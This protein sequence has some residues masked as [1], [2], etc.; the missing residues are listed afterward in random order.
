MADQGAAM[1]VSPR[2]EDPSNDTKPQGIQ[3]QAATKRPRAEDD[4]T[5]AADAQPAPLS[6]SPDT[7]RTKTD[8]TT[9]T[10]E[11][12]DASEATMNI[13]TPEVTESKDESPQVTAAANDEA[14]GE[15]QNRQRAN[16]WLTSPAV[17]RRRAT[18]TTKESNN[19]ESNDGVT[20]HA[21]STPLEVPYRSR[22]GGERWIGKYKYTLLRTLV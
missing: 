13:E 5:D 14:S 20:D 1:E 19:G 15:G 18:A 7:K 11:N 3:E 21:T 16:G 9:S 22:I 12:G 2:E 6:D 10:T 8:N 4:A 17:T